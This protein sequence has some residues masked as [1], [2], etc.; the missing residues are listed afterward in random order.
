MMYHHLNS[1]RCSNNIDIFESHIKYISENFNSTFPTENL[2]SN[3]ICLV[4]DDG[5]YDFYKLIFPLLKKYNIKALLAVIPKY[6][7]DDCNYSDEDRL[8]YDH[9]DL[10]K[11]YN[12]G[13]FCTFKELQEMVDSELVQVVSHSY[14]HANLV[15]D[16]ISLEEELKLSKQIIEDKLYT[17]NNNKVESFVYPFGKYNQSI[18][19]ETMKYYKYSFRIGNGINKDFSGINGVIYRIDGDNLEND[20]DIFRFSN[21]L[22]FRFKSFVKQIVGN[23]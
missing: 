21:M 20:S 5:Y 11:Y 18:L 9:N 2:P 15:E 16:D 3:P 10:F 22:K 4:F 13:T 23:R 12:M 19:D 8:N 6:I 1:D 7:L 17:K 14:S